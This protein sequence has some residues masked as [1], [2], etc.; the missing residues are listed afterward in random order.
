MVPPLSEADQ[1][2]MLRNRLKDKCANKQTNESKQTHT[3]REREKR[4]WLSLLA[5]TVENFR[6]SY[7]KINKEFATVFKMINDKIDLILV[8]QCRVGITHS[9]YN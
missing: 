3:Q 1:G 2:V 5:N 8:P 7:F 6:A 9:P 4:S